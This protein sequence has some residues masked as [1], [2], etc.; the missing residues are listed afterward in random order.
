[1]PDHEQQPDILS[2][3]LR[4]AG[5]ALASLGAHLLLFV[6]SLAGAGLILA[7]YSAGPGPAPSY[8][9][10]FLTAFFGL[11]CLIPEKKPASL[12]ELAPL[13][14]GLFLC[15]CWAWLG[16]P[17]QFTPIWGA[18]AAFLCRLLA[19]KG[20][21]GFEWLQLPFLLL[22]LAAYYSGLEAAAPRPAPLVT[23]PLFALGGWLVILARDKLFALAEARRRGAQLPDPA[24]T[25][26]LEAFS[27]RARHLAHKAESLP[28]GV[29]PKVLG[30]AAGTEK[31]L[32]SMRADA[33][34]T[35]AGDRFLS[36]YLKAAHDVVDEYAR[37]AA[38]ADNR[39]NVAE[40]LVR[41]ERTLA[42]LE[43]AFAEERL[44]MLNNDTVNFRAQLK[45]LDK[46][47]RMDGRQ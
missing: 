6:S 4:L 45:V 37:L 8:F 1:M 40:A 41:A 16:L 34:D 42:A 9:A 30:I 24:L 2:A 47:L 38:E 36:R 39:P 19:A 26:K 31:L 44:R 35:A 15:A 21:L 18:A 46:L 10:L 28:P 17:W 14:T 32:D 33:G 3:P 7:S 23:L 11:S 12:R 29:R 13:F 20:R 22:G 27:D 5:K 43:Q 25:A